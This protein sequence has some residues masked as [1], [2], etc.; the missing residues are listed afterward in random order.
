MDSCPEPLKNWY[1]QFSGIANSEVGPNSKVCFSPFGSHS[2]AE[3]WP[4]ST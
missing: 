3:P 1:W 4:E 2:V